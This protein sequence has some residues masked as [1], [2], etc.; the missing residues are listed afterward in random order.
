MHTG[1]AELN[2]KTIFNL[3]TSLYCC[4]SATAATAVAC[5]A[6]ARS[7]SHAYERPVARKSADNEGLL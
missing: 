2:L 7:V 3:S 6:T 1:S 5:A 4:L